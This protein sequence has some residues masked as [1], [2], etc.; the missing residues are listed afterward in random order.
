M[1][2][3]AEEK[4]VK[5]NVL[6]IF[7]QTKE[8][9]ED[10]QQKIADESKGFA[11][12]TR[13][14]MDKFD[15]YRVRILPNCPVFHDDGTFTLDRKSYEYPVKS[16][17]LKLV[18][19]VSKDKKEQF[20]YVNVCHGS[21]VG[22]S[23]DLIDTYK[24]AAV[25]YFEAVGDSKMADKLKGG[26]FGG[27]LKYDSKRAMLILN[28]DNRSE[29]AQLLEL[30]YSQYKD[31]EERKM[32]LWKKK[33]AK[34]ERYPCPISSFDRAYPVEITKKKDKDSGKTVYLFTIDNESDADELSVEELNGLIAA[35][36]LPEI[37]YRYSRYHLEATV[38]FLRQ[39]DEKLGVDLFSSE[40][41]QDALSK[42]KIEL[43]AGDTSHFS[44]DKKENDGNGTEEDGSAMT[45]DLLW[46][47]YEQLQDENLSDKSDEGQELRVLIQQ[48]IIDNKLMARVRRGFTNLQVLQDIEDELRSGGSDA[49]SAKVPSVEDANPAP[50]GDDLLD[51]SE[52]P[53]RT[54]ERRVAR[55]ERKR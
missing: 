39:T 48:Y 13:F 10:A 33:L 52:S 43:P 45:L 7:S 38:E 37:L 36:R 40:A 11:K 54:R 30:S 35:P 8:S 15:T 49:A 17:L 23:V 53:T 6:E 26:S 25:A 18:A 51:E 14:I 41:V 1:T 9:F 44:F 3:D 12:I 24:E 29:G 50:I 34:D 19:P 28:L 16:M 46:E 4:N 27:G 5:L 42:I 55:S 31:L 32:N 47:M 20:V 22:L 21:Q 2:R